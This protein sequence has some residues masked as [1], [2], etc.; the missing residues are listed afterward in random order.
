MIKYTTYRFKFSALGF[1]GSEING[2]LDV[3]VISRKNHL[4]TAKEKAKK[5][6]IEK[7]VIFDGC[8]IAFTVLGKTESTF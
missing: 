1:M 4:R 7:G 6:L 5:I 3:D 2:F 8:K